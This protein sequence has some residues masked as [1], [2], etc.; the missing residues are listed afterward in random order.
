MVEFLANVL[1]D[2]KLTSS[3]FNSHRMI[4]QIDVYFDGEKVS[5]AQCLAGL[6]SQFG[7]DKD[8]FKLHGFRSDRCKSACVAISF[9]IHIHA[10]H[11]HTYVSTLLR[12]RYGISSQSRSMPLARV[13]MM[14]G[15]NPELFSERGC[16]DVNYSD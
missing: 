2:L 13:V 15:N 7:R 4:N 11:I 9:H 1:L 14:G 12:L 6:I 5:D 16:S 10:L 8:V 3:T